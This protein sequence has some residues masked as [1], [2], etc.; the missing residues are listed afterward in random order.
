MGQANLPQKSLVAQVLEEL[1]TLLG[2]DHHFT[3]DVLEQLASLA[4]SGGLKKH[5]LIIEVLKHSGGTDG[6][7]VRTRS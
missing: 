5:P 3:P 1:L 2:Q 7:A 4:K 6:E